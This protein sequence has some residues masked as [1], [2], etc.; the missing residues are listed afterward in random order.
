MISFFNS[1]FLIKKFLIFVK[2]YYK[3]KLYKILKIKT[4]IKNQNI[5]FLKNLLRKLIILQ[6]SILYIW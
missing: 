6:T 5:F 4:F 1:K 3:N 2:S